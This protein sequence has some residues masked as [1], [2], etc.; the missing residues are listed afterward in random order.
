MTKKLA[1]FLILADDFSG[2]CEVSLP[3]S[4]HGFSTRISL[5]YDRSTSQ[6]THQVV[7]ADTNSRYLE[8]AAAYQRIGTLSQADATHTSIFKK[9]DSLWRGNINAEIK[10][11]VDQGHTLIIAGALPHLNRS[12]VNGRPLI[13]GQPLWN[14]DAWHVEA[15]QAPD[16]IAQLLSGM[17]STN[18]QDPATLDSDAG[19]THQLAT[20]AATHQA[21]IVDCATDADLRLIARTWLA[22]RADAQQ[23]TQRSILV[24][25]GALNAALARELAAAAVPGSV[26]NEQNRPPISTGIR[27]LLSVVGSASGPSGKQLDLAAQAGIPCA[28]TAE[29][30]PT[31]QDGTPVI[32]RATRTKSTPT[33]VL[34]QLRSQVTSWL[35]TRPEADLFLTGGETARAVLDDLEL[36]SLTPIQELEPGV[37]ICQASDGRLIGTKP[38][39]FGSPNIL[40]QALSTLRQLRAPLSQET[41]Q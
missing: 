34:E 41:K 2:A 21:V 12:V 37:V 4:D 39:S 19:F 35:R 15:N 8:P 27:P 23:R 32:L 5:D 9:I 6:N 29:E 22:L 24:G 10:A 28:E 31:P 13:D 11:L 33:Q 16:S 38:G 25:T 40:T 1:E 26:A 36:T 18:I 20:A 7:V 17:E 30:L 14:T 3:W